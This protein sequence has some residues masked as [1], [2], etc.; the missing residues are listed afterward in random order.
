MRRRII[1]ANWKM[2]KNYQQGLEL[3]S[4]VIQIVADEVN[5]N[6]EVVLAVPFIHLQAVTRLA[7]SN[8]RIAVAAQN[9]STETEGAYTGETSAGQIAS[10]GARYVLVGHS[11]RR[12][13]FNEDGV[14]LMRKIE[15]TLQASMAPIFCCGEPLSIRDQGQENKF[16]ASQLND[17]LSTY[18]KADLHRLV[19]AYEPIWAIGTGRTATAAQ[20]QAM[21]A[22]IRT[23]LTDLFGENAAQ[24]IPILYGGSVKASN[25]VELFAQPDI[26]GGLVGGASL[27]SREFA[28]IC[29]A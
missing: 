9:C 18:P 23:V 25:A 16:V 2:N 7:A 21:H 29:K 28:N 19:L 12:E 3:A 6:A 1:A 4:E 13:Y 22:H 8:S 11:E 20:A 14:V 27:Q 26:D 10:T 17:V 15:Q 24:L 5:G